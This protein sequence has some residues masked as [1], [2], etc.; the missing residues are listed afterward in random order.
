[1]AYALCFCMRRIG[2]GLCTESS[3]PYRIAKSNQI[4]AEFNDLKPLKFERYLFAISAIGIFPSIYFF[5]SVSIN[6]IYLPRRDGRLSWPRLHAA[7]S[8]TRNFSIT[9]PTP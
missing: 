6:S 4:P 9:S 2:T 5:T 3:T 7:R 8:Q 1:M